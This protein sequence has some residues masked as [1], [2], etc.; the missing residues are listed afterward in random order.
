LITDSSDEMAIKLRKCCERGKVG[1]GRGS[2]SWKG[3]CAMDIRGMRG[4]WIAMWSA[5]GMAVVITRSPLIQ[6]LDCDL[7]VVIGAAMLQNLGLSST[8]QLANF[9]AYSNKSPLSTDFF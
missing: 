1:K 8:S 7:I 5:S 6:S 9:R 4:G 3:N 2:Y